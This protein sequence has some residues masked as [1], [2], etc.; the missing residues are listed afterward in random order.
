[1]IRA[2]NL[3]EDWPFMI[4]GGAEPVV[5]SDTQG[6]VCELDGEVAAMVVMDS[7]SHNSVQVHMTIKNPMALRHGLLEEVSAHV[8]LVAGRGILIGLVPGDNEKALKLNK[9]LGY[10]EVHRIKDGFSVSVDT[11]IMELRAE[12]NRWLQRWKDGRKEQRVAA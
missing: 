2:M 10:T 5:C 6:I 11:V 4:D 3:V 1:M 9:H 8:H 12:N 7:W